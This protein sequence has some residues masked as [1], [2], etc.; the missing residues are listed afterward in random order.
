M[1]TQKGTEE[2][3]AEADSLPLKPF[4][5]MTDEQ[6][7]DHVRGLQ[8]IIENWDSATFMTLE[9]AMEKLGIELVDVTLE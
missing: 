7:A 5:S 3:P 2:S 4:S 8:E 9:E 1:A 6:W